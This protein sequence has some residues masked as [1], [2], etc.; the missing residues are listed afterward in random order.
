MAKLEKKKFLLNAIREV[1]SGLL[2]SQ[3][4]MIRKPGAADRRVKPSD[5]G[6][7]VRSNR[8]GK[9]IRDLLAQDRI[10]SI[11]IDDT[12]L[13][14][15]NQAKELSFVM[16][17]VLDTTRKHIHRALLTEIGGYDKNSLLSADE[18]AIL[19]RFK[20]YQETWNARGVYEML[21]QFL[22]DHGLAERL[23][24]D[25][26]GMERTVSNLLQIIELIH[27]VSERKN[28]D[29]REQIQW[30]KRG[31]DGELREGDEYEQR[32]ESDDDAVRIVTIH[33][34]KGLE[35]N[36]VIAPHLDSLLPE[37]KGM[38]Q[39]SFRD[40][41]SGKYYVVDKR[42]RTPEEKTW[43][44]EQNEQENRRLM[45][46][47]VTRAR[48][49]CFITANMWTG[50]GKSTLRTFMKAI[51]TPNPASTG[52][53]IFEPEEVIT[54]PQPAPAG[55]LPARQ[56][57]VAQH[58]SLDNVNWKRTSYTGLNP[59][60]DAAMAELDPNKVL[61]GYEHFMFRQ[62][63]KGAHT[64]NLLHYIF[65]NINFTDDSNWKAV[66]EKALKRLSGSTDEAYAS[67]IVNMLHQVIHTELIPGS[68]LM[69]DKIPWH[70]RLNE[71]EF[72]IP[73]QPF[74]TDAIQQLSTPEI[75]LQVKYEKDLEGIL[76]GKMDLFFE[77]EG[78]Y[79]ILDW[80]SNHLGDRLEYY[81]GQ[82]L[83]EAMAGNNYHLQYHLYTVA[84]MRFLSLR[85]PGFDYRRDFGGV[86]YLFLR[87]IRTG[88]THGIFFHKPDENTV[89]AMRRIFEP[90]V[91]G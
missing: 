62:L 58:F 25:A 54:R 19:Q 17:A 79:Y 28:Y 40:P 5:I 7:L 34:S 45:Y 27:K 69:L 61:E 26:S 35:Y 38:T 30:L 37:P 6:I 75:P 83:M 53:E 85:V 12:K 20:T 71:L 16:Q 72:D 82:R 63:R 77:Y 81:Q 29:P 60:H 33:K 42:F 24:A 18:E 76:N 8:E 52:I 21:R 78:K 22:S 32:I 84:A 65:E 50:Y 90:A 15:S 66:T 57:A 10:A 4:Y 55:A 91:V 68:G 46:V 2:F 80:K 47:A 59:A 23:M 73:L 36:I 67:Q 3:D 44:D 14:Q 31:L 39:F 11:T 88:G 87:G 9:K 74:H 41:Q 64:G 89:F 1:V 86:C 43:C 70:K 49:A 51:G 13:L 56:V 48:L